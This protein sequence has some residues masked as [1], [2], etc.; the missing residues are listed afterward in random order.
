MNLPL[1]GPHAYER[2][3]STTAVGGILPSRLPPHAN[4][5]RARAAENLSSLSPN[6][7]RIRAPA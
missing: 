2:I 6:E 3:P 1:G 4:T 7:L 5:K